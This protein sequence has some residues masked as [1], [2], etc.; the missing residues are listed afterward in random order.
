MEL[1]F[2]DVNE[3]R[4]FH[5]KFGAFKKKVRFLLCKI[6]KIMANVYVITLMVNVI[7]AIVTLMVKVLMANVILESLTMA[8]FCISFFISCSMIFLKNLTFIVFNL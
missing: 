7:K 8:N 1:N 3:V 6:V 2:S 4:N 5:E